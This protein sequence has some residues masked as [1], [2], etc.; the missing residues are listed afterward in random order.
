MSIQRLQK[1]VN[2]ALNNTSEGEARNAASRFFKT[3]KSLDMR[4]SSRQF[5]I[6]KADALR[7]ADLG[8]VVIKG[9]TPTKTAETKPVKNQSRLKAEFGANPFCEKFKSVKECCYYFFAQCDMNN[10]SERRDT[11][12]YLVF[13]FKFDKRSVQSYASNYRRDSAVN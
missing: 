8:G 12:D 5:G 4:F 6:S 10:S 1:Y 11:I 9:E 2:L 7:L 13:D 3:L